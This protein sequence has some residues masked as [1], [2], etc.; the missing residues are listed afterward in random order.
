MPQL[1]AVPVRALIQLCKLSAKCLLPLVSHRRMHS[2]HLTRIRLQVGRKKKGRHAAA[3]FL[4]GTSEGARKAGIDSSVSIAAKPDKA[5]L[6][7]RSTHSSLFR[8]T[9][10]D[11]S[12][13]RRTRLPGVVML[14]RAGLFLRRIDGLRDAP[15]AVS[16]C[17]SSG[18][19]AAKFGRHSPESERRRR[20]PICELRV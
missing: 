3:H 14:P 6:L 2:C 9:A 11:R 19:F 10:E 1:R 4:P 20:A 16:P 18:D 13:T 15:A 12:L 8:P 17:H 5:I 7:E